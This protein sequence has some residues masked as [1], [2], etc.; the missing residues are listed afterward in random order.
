[1]SYDSI[2]FNKFFLNTIFYSY[3][4]FEKML[5]IKTILTTMIQRLLAI[6]GII[7][8]LPMMA[9]VYIV[10]RVESDGKVFYTQTRIGKNGVPFT[11]YKFRS[12]YIQSDVR[13]INIDYLESDRKGACKKF[14]NDPRV[15]C[16]GRVIR[17]LSIDELPQL[18]NIVKG[19]MAFVGPRPAL[20]KEVSKY[21]SNAKRR[22]NILPG[23]TGL[24][25]VSGRADTSFEE[26]M[27]LDIN[28]VLNQ[29]F[30]LDLKILLMTI[31]AVISGK[32]AY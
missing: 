10:I 19:E 15:T 14:K 24:W 22:L 7:F 12:M 32:G 8:I 17:K 4:A 20:P 29:S 28:Y 16:V 2:C 23:L 6:I 26:Q 25:Q 1:M 13:R 18:I 31:P 9:L 5:R 21:D 30:L 11:M 3:M 27:K